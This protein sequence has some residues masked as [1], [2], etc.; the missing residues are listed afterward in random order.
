VCS[1]APWLCA[2]ASAGLGYSST[3]SKAGGGRGGLA[4]LALACL[5]HT[6]RQ[7]GRETERIER[8][9]LGAHAKTER[10]RDGENRETERI[11]RRRE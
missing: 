5:A 3:S 1:G 7:R 11:E 6:Q 9:R 8:R 4:R 2:R 10:Q